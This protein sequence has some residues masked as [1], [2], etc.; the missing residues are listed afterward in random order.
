MKPVELVGYLALIITVLYTCL[1]I[2]AQIRKN[3]Q[4][5]ST[6]GLSLPTYVLSLLCFA[7]W[8]VYGLLKEQKD[9]FII[10]S[11]FPGAVFVAIILYQFWTYRDRD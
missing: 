7:V 5:K 11:N 1:G 9:W 6:A 10:V 2:P 8:V 3:A 4:Q